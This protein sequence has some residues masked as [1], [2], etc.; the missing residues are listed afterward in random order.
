M[1]RWRQVASAS[2]LVLVLPLR[3]ACG[4]TILWDFNSDPPGSLPPNW[5]NGWNLERAGCDLLPGISQSCDYQHLPWIVS[6]GTLRPPIYFDDPDAPNEGMDSYAESPAFISIS[7]PNASSDQ[8]VFRLAVSF[9]PSNIGR[10]K[11]FLDALQIHLLTVGTSLFAEVLELGLDD[12]GPWNTADAADGAIDRIIIREISIEPNVQYRLRIRSSDYDS[13]VGSFEGMAIDNIAATNGTIVGPFVPTGNFD[14]DHDV[15][16]ADFLAWQRNFGLGQGAMLGQ[17][18]A[19]GNGAV[20][21]D[22]LAVW[23]GQFGG[24]ADVSLGDPVPEP[25][26]AYLAFLGVAGAI[27]CC[28]RLLA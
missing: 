19:D 22:D 24:S 10:S 5:T 3:I 7:P 17:G 25:T 11:Q 8:P 16:G 1:C 9:N 18:D 13:D 6:N 2:A 14:G 28:R 27:D 4:Q 15:D 23:R 20:T 21:G 26:A 12:V